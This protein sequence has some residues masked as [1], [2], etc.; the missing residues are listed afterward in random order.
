MTFA[1]LAEWTARAAP[2]QKLT[3]AA[4]R[5][6]QAELPAFIRE[7]TPA[8]APQSVKLPTGESLSDATRMTALKCH[9]LLLAR[10]TAG[11]GYVKADPEYDRLA[12]DVL[13]YVMRHAFNTDDP[14]GVFCCP[15]CTLSLL[16]LYATRCFRWVKCEELE[17]N[18]LNA[19][20]KGTSV[21]AR[22]YPKNYAMWAVGFS[23]SS[24]RK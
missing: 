7:L 10:V 11:A 5:Q 6:I 15:P 23:R 14:K 18:V 16:P 2:G 17:S 9:C 8:H 20:A 19:L 1:H 24:S 3:P 12:K 22:S 4:K 21:F 13:F